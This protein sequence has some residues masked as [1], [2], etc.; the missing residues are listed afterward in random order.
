MGSTHIFRTRFWRNNLK[1]GLQKTNYCSLNLLACF[2]H[3]RLRERWKSIISCERSGDDTLLLITSYIVNCEL[4][5]WVFFKDL[6]GTFII[7]KNFF[8][9]NR[10]LFELVYVTLSERD[11]LCFLTPLTR[12]YSLRGNRRTLARISRMNKKIYKK[13]HKDL[14]KMYSYLNNILK[15]GRLCFFQCPLV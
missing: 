9:S 8:D 1:G 5:Y 10:S 13:N 4:Y 14:N 3:F 2:L 6:R 15:S 12:Y 11:W 7:K